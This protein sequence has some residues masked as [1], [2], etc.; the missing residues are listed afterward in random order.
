[1]TLRAPQKLFPWFLLG[2]VGLFVL[3]LIACVQ[4]FRRPWKPYQRRYIQSQRLA[5]EGPAQKRAA[6]NLQMGIR[7][8]HVP[9]LGRVDRCTTCHLAVNHPD[10]A[11]A[12]HPLRSHVYPDRHPFEEFGCTVCHRGDGLATTASAAH[13]RRQ[14]SATPMLP[15]SFVIAS[16]MA[17]HELDSLPGVERLKAGR[18]LF[19][20]NGCL[21]CHS[22]KGEGG[23]AAPALDGVGL[24]RSLDWMIRH[25]KDPAGVSPGS[26]MPAVKLNEQDI[27]NLALYVTG[28][29]E[30]VTDPVFSALRVLPT[31]EAGRELYFK[32]GCIGCHGLGT[33][34]GDYGPD[35]T[36]LGR[37]GTA[38]WLR[39]SLQH[40]QAGSRMPHPEL[41][42]DEREALVTFLL[43]LSDPKFLQGIVD[44]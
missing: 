19:E 24:R 9:A 33:I 13:G 7:Q 12:A 14:G 3:I 22:L 35:L 29:T 5:A 2:S 8:I 16:C 11:D 28:L 10:Y 1:M 20:N 43:R 15:T 17:C 26:A 38:A 42:P 41:R 37:R 23:R 31:A 39:F 30:P 25:F 6:A 34:G 27:E 18:L 40:P 36:Q 44:P 21:A 32:R 4:D